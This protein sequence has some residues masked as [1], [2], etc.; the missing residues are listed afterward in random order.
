MGGTFRTIAGVIL[1]GIIT[2]SA[3]IICQ[4]VGRT[5]RVD[6]TELK[7]YTLSDGSK[8][9]LAKLN[10]P[11]K[12]RLFYT[13]TAT[14]KARDEIRYYNNY[15]YF[16]QSLLEEYARAAKGM[17]K[18]DIIDPRPFSDE[19]EEALRYG[20]TRFPI[21]EEENFF[22]GLVLQT[23]FGVV[24]TIPFFSP[25]RQNFVEYDLSSLIDTAITR[26]KKRIGVLSSLPVMGEQVTGYMAW[27]MQQQNQQ[28]AP[29]W[30]IVRQL[31][32]QYDVNEVATDVNEIEDIDTLLV[33]HPKD[34][35]EKTLF[36][37]DQFVLKGGRAIICV[38]P[39]CLVDNPKR[40]P[41]QMQP[42]ADPVSNLDGLLR[43]WGVEMPGDEFAGD[44]SL[45]IPVRMGQGREQPHIGLLGLT[46][47][48][49]NSK[50]IVTANLNEV[51]LVFSGVLRN[52]A[53]PEVEEGMP[54]NEITPLLQTTEE[55]NTWQVAGPWDWVRIVPETL[56][57][58]FREGTEPVVMSCLITG[59]FRSAFP[60]GIEVPAESDEDKSDEEG[61]S[62]GG[63]E[64]AE[65]KTKKLTGLTE[66]VT[67]CAVIV[68]A[69]VDFISDM[70]YVAYQDTIFG[71][72]AISNNSDFLLNAIEFM[73]GSGDL[74]AIRSRGNFRRPFDVVE[75][76]KDEAEKKTAVEIAKRNAEIKALQKELDDIVASAEGSEE[77]IIAEEREKKRRQAA[78]KLRQAQRDLNDIQ[79]K[80]FVE[81]EQLRSLLQNINTWSAPVVILIIAVFLS[82]RRSVLRRR[83]VSHASDA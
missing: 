65:K 77:S 8:S 43:T 36:A 15:F 64:E 81:I 10:Q 16:V 70:P 67:D 29:P 78:L 6:I 38:D 80:R 18:L 26:E 45:A 62:E 34:L 72:A 22:F 47:D 69:D 2:F 21:S 3:I 9:I 51:R 27:L 44:R 25:Q 42:S 5:L 59:R 68:V 52:V 75:G 20:L 61:E 76:I 7:L 71:K 48:S 13:K 19:E 55:G 57:T 50:N 1:V 28:P 56:M 17:I 30:T 60:E 79:R 39:R 53:S 14:R 46:G 35:P 24:K 12:L 40:M 32:Q 54:Q 82:I 41:G 31:Q 83:Y 73:G 37:I 11:L 33:I 66:A 23:E 49:F 63:D 4:D 58:Y 74:I